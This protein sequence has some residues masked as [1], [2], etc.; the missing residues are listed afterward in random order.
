MKKLFFTLTL[1]SVLCVTAAPLAYA[2]NA[3]APAAA[4]TTPGDRTIHDASTDL[5]EAL[6]KSGLNSFQ[7]KPHEL[8][9]VDP[10][11]DT[12]TSLIFTAID[13]LKYVLGTIAVIMATISGVKLITAGSKADEAFEKERTALKYIIF[14]L[15]LVMIADQLVTK[16]FFGD[17]GECIASASNAKE[18]S[19]V[20]SSLIKGI[21]DFILAMMASVSLFV[22]VLS[23]FR[24]VSAAGN[25]DVIGKAKKR[26]G[27]SIAGLLVSAVA[28]FAIKGIIF[29]DGGKEG[30]D[31]A[32]A[33]MLVINFTNFVAA[34]IGFGSFLMLVYGGYLYVASFGN[35]DQTGKAKKI[36]Q[37]ALIGVVIAITAFAIVTTIATFNSRP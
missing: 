14:G 29:R 30:I 4:A 18:C 27:F 20:G 31:V 24:M 12:I 5:N 33:N 37:S 1:I 34:F 35:E 9:S 17:Y 19:K 16:V 3:P 36:I 6:G 25:D 2:Q 21:Y 23:G 8:S 7:N 26:I 15:I 28:E 22:L 10:G 32:S 13:I 11:A